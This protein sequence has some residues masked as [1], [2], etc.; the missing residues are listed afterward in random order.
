M[1]K[2]LIVLGVLILVSGISFAQE[3]RGNFYQEEKGNFNVE[4]S[5]GFPVHWSNGLH[6]DSFYAK[7]PVDQPDKTV[8]ANTSIGLGFAYSIS[9]RISI[10]LDTDF[11]FGARLAGFANPTSDYNSIFGANAFI[12]PVFNLYN[13]GS[14]KIPLGI[15]MHFSYFADEIWLPETDVLGSDGDWIKRQDF[16]LGPGLFLGIQYHFSNSLYIFSR[17]NVAIDIFRLHSIKGAKGSDYIN[18]KH[19]E[20]AANWVVKPSLGVGIRF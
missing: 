15:G 13:S 6:D 3:E 8:T 10:N 11:L 12:G 2:L 18:E 20:F 4:L 19:T 1:K 5:Y 17:T 7:N 16:Q 14:L 9:N